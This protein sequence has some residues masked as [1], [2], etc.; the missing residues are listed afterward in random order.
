MRY[1]MAS[2]VVVTRRISYH[3]CLQITLGTQKQG[4]S[5]ARPSNLAMLKSLQPAGD[6]AIKSAIFRLKITYIADRY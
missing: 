3:C 4:C 2:G 6:G 1:R 5:P